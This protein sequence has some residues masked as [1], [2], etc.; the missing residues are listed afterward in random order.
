MTETSRPAREHRP[1]LYRHIKGA[2]Y[3]AYETVLLGGEP[4]VVYRPLYGRHGLWLRPAG[5]FHETVTRDDRTAPRFE[6]LDKPLP[7]LDGEWLMEM[8]ARHTEEPPCD[9]IVE[10][11]M[12]IFLERANH[13]E[14]EAELA[15]L[16]DPEA[17]GLL[18]VPAAEFDAEPNGAPVARERLARI[19]GIELSAEW[20]SVMTMLEDE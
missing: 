5:M 15:V 3:R 10:G 4:H 7:R 18:A 14:T 12:L 6:R 16:L 19:A 17:P 1:G 9:A 20:A 11:R 2:R 8:R 13:S